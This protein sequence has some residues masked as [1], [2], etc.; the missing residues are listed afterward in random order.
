MSHASRSV[1]KKYRRAQRK[2]A[3]IA[4]QLPEFPEGRWIR[5]GPPE[6]VRLGQEH[7]AAA[8]IAVVAVRTSAPRRAGRG[9]WTK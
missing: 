6:R 7:Y 2:L 8:D 9:I 4:A 1:S 5:P 3:S